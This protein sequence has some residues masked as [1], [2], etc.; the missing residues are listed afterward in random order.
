MTKDG[1]ALPRDLAGFAA[2]ARA[3]L[4]P[5]AWA[6]LARGDDP[7]ANLAAWRRL[8]LRPRILRGV[9]SVDLRPNVLGRALASPILL[10]P[11]GRATRYHPQG[12]QAVLAGAQRAGALAVLASS[13]SPSLE[14]LMAT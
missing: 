1:A 6:Y 7:S 5:A 14:P 2:A 13:V 4:H 11:T 12:E 9:S 3:R 8:K 10:A